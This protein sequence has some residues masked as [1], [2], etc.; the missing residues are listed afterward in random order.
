MLACGAVWS[1][2]VE[3]GT[4]Q[5]SYQNAL[6]PYLVIIDHIQYLVRMSITQFEAH[7]FFGDVVEQQLQLVHVE[8]TFTT[9]RRILRGNRIDRG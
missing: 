8:L 7:E 6:M 5:P 9:R 4:S 2:T 3:R 1:V